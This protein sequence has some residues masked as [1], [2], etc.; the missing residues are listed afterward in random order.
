MPNSYLSVIEKKN[1]ILL[2]KSGRNPKA[3]LPSAPK[4]TGISDNEGVRVWQASTAHL[5]HRLANSVKTP[6]HGS[7]GGAGAAAVT[8]SGVPTVAGWDTVTAC[9]AVRL[10][11]GWKAC[12]DL[13]MGNPRGEP[14]GTE[15]D[16]VT[17]QGGASDL[18]PLWSPR[19]LCTHRQRA[20]GEIRLVVIPVYFHL[21]F[22]LSQSVIL[23]IQT[24]VLLATS[25]INFLL[26]VFSR[27]FFLMNFHSIL[28]LAFQRRE[29]ILHEAQN[30]L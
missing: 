13:P 28:D 4:G 27:R 22:T 6:G 10:E 11:T 1:E 17:R 16:R 3:E 14:E 9:W 18:R 12:V 25:I 29:K 30:L 21:E 19:P 8:H 20:S 15:S 24:N 5:P 7:F 23:W 26:M 2:V